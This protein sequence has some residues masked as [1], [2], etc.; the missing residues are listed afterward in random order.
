MRTVRIKSNGYQCDNQT[1]KRHVLLWL[2]CQ[3]PRSS[4]KHFIQTFLACCS[5]SPW[6]TAFLSVG[7]P[8]IRGELN[9]DPCTTAARAA[10]RSAFKQTFCKVLKVATQTLWWQGNIVVL[11]KI[12]S[13][14]FE[15]A[16]RQRLASLLGGQL[17]LLTLLRF[18]H[19]VAVLAYWTR[20]ATVFGHL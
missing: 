10:R 17:V 14:C 11:R 9:G 5:F 20:A 4:C 16:N 18:N 1:A 2:L 8:S 13:L 7:V 19:L 12:S 6:A 3:L 15:Q